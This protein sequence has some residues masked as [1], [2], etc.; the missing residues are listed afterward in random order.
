VRIKV[1]ELKDKVTNYIQK[2]LRNESYLMGNIFVSCNEHAEWTFLFKA[3]K[4]VTFN[5][6]NDID[7]IKNGILCA[8][9]CCVAKMLDYEFSMTPKYAGKK[10]SDTGNGNVIFHLHF[11][12]SSWHVHSKATY[13]VVFVLRKNLVK[14]LLIHFLQIRTAYGCACFTFAW[15]K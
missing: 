12:S 15:H 14:N 5:R 6:R 11:N 8:A 7:A 10:I 2:V 4:C 9:E 3:E 13:A 1:G